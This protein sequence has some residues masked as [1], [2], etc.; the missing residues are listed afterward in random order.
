MFKTF[1]SARVGLSS[2]KGFTNAIFQALLF[3]Q[4]SRFQVEKDSCI[5]ELNAGQKVFKSSIVSIIERGN[6]YSFSN[7]LGY[8]L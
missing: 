6:N 8:L 2:P 5:C 1:F 3:Y 7:K 4:I